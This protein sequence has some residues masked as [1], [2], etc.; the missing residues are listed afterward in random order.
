[1]PNAKF[2]IFLIRVFLF[3]WAILM[4]FNLT[5]PA[6]TKSTILVGKVVDSIG[7]PLS[8]VNI[9]IKTTA[10]S[11][12]T[13]ENG[14]FL[15]KVMPGNY[16]LQASF[17]GYGNTETPIILLSQRN[18]IVIK[19]STTSKLM[20][21][22][23]IT[24]V[25][26]QSAAAT[27]TLTQLQDIPQA[28]TIVGQEIIRQQAAFDL[29]TITKNISGL[30][31]TG[32]YSG[33]GS[34]QFFNARGFDLNESQ[35]YRWNGVMIWNWGNNYTDNIEQVEFLKGP[36]S[37]LFGDVAPGGV[38]NFVTKKPLANFMANVDVKLGSW[39]L[40][41]PSLDV[42]GS[43][44][45][46]RTLRYRLNTSY[47]QSNSFRNQVASQ[48]KFIAPA[49]AWD[50]TPKLK[51]E[52]ESVFKTAQATDDAGLVSP[53][54][55]TAG[56]ENLAPT[57]YLGEPSRKYNY[58]DESYFS[59]LTY[60]L[61]GTWR[62][63]STAFYS[64]T[65][66]RP[67]G[68]WFDK[69]DAD[70][71]YVRRQYG[72][73]QKAKNGTLALNLYGSFYTNSIKHQVLFG[74]EYQSTTYRQTNGGE[75][76]ILDQNN[77]Y[78]PVYGQ[79]ITEEP[80]ETL[81]RPY[82]T[83]VARSGFHFQD[84]LLLFKEKLQ[85]LLGFRLGKTRQGNNYLI[86]ETVG[87]PYEGYTDDIVSRNVFTPR[88]GIVYKPQS[89]YSI[90]ASYSKGYEINSPDL[91]AQNYMQYARPPATISMQIEFGAKM[92]LLDNKFGLTLSAFEI[93][94]Y[95]PY[96]YVYVNSLNPN[97]D[98][99]NVY[100]E[101]HHQSK[102]IEV[103]ADGT[104]LPDVTFL[105][106][107]AYTRAKVISDPGYPAGNTLPNAPKLSANAWVNFEP[108]LQFKGISLGTG[109]FYK[110]SFFSGLGNDPN[111]I[112]PKSYTWDAAIGYTYR[113]VGIRLNVMNIT[114]RVSY[115]NPWQFNLFDVRP[116]RQFVIT[117]NYHIRKK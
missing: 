63:K 93:N 40:I 38:M 11:C 73:Y 53:D 26:K 68:L 108:S 46:S 25:K 84:Q 55:T 69:P 10:V 104:I 117:L 60:E 45:S 15:L 5:L 2:K 35:N 101:G 107:L 80:S 62:I 30:N 27:R 89:N 98:L 111:L 3:F 79:S 1:M 59:T 114:N 99:Y 70:G 19:L 33:A 102:G 41:R 28:I 12:I 37:I 74:F 56:L 109:F 77:I 67:F 22:V 47:E 113:A 43:I 29:S 71:N 78:T 18:S 21:E 95:D 44:D 112:I 110:G 39:G 106:G 52:L 17:L 20:Q 116:L 9:A 7:L 34:S 88:V 86:T 16:L 61:N 72:F 96:G 90:Y 31:F 51:W 48:R 115:L 8:G 24:G 105:G 94:K 103:E 97:Y 66:N 100:Y 83:G 50:I 91:F 87:T 75:L 92:N 23:T 82:L 57:L 76:S 81:L 65:S 58:K 6:Q 14:N 13:D 54:G 32:N 42:T 85:V 36:T 4:A 64:H 49:L